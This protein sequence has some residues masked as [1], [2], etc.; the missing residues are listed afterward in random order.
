MSDL[1]AGPDAVAG[2]ASD[3][4]L[5]RLLAGE[6]GADER[7]TL[8]AH[9]S[10]C[11]TCSARHAEFSKQWQT[12]AA[13]GPDFST[14]VLRVNRRRAARDGRRSRRVYVAG[15]VAVAAAAVLA[16]APIA[17]STSDPAPDQTRSK[18]KPHIGYFVKRG[19]AVVDGVPGAALHPGDRIRF[20]T[21]SERP[22]YLA[23]LNRDARGVSVYYP[24]TGRAARVPAGSAVPLDFS[25]K[26]DDYLG[27]ERVFAVFCDESFA[28]EPVRAAL[29]ANGA[30]PMSAGCSV[31]TLDL[32]K[33][34]GP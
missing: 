31:A 34:S 25:V 7:E 4:R 23:L 28:V 16:F 32:E 27:R 22:R 11:E 33:E 19:E 24:S 21:S 14:L 29:Q 18:G 1:A 8:L 10:E 6:L 30:P 15:V 12:L 13:D 20:V 26:L 3:L 17:P 5:D 9:V 2:C